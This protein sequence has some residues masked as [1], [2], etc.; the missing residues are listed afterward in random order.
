MGTNESAG[1]NRKK[2][3]TLNNKELKAHLK[4]QKDTLQQPFYRSLLYSTKCLQRMLLDKTCL[5]LNR[6]NKRE[7][8]DEG[9]VVKCTEKKPILNDAHISLYV[10]TFLIET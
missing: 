4:S 5:S 7:W 9:T 6:R 1:P 8:T 2:K 10:S 3:K